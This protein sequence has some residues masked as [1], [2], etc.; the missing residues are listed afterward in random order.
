MCT[1]QSEHA[2][3]ICPVAIDRVRARLH[4]AFGALVQ[5]TTIEEQGTLIQIPSS[6]DPTQFQAVT[7]E[8]I[9]AV[10]DASPHPT[11]A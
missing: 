4:E 10:Q 5:C 2:V 3:L 11:G 9:A 8:A 6:V 7:R 1:F